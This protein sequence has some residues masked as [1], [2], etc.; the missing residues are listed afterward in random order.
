M[1][2]YRIVLL[3]LTLLMMTVLYT[4]VNMIHIDLPKGIA[5]APLP[6]SINEN[7][8]LST[9][10]TDD[11]GGIQTE[12]MAFCLQYWEQTANALKN[13]M[14]LQCWAKLNNI[15]K[16]LEPSIHFNSAPI[17]HF[18]NGNNKS[19]KFGD[20]FD[21]ENWNNFAS[22]LE[23]APLV[24]LQHFL[25][26]ATKELVYVQ[27]GHCH[28][29][30]SLTQKVWYSYLTT[31]GFRINRTACIYFKS[32]FMSES[33]FH[34]DILG[35]GG[36][37]FS[38]LFELWKG[39][40]GSGEPKRI[41]LKDSACSNCLS[42]YATLRM[43]PYKPKA[44]EYMPESSVYPILPSKRI[45]K[46]LDAFIERH[47]AGQE[48][49]AV[50]LRTEKIEKPV[51]LSRASVCEKRILADVNGM[52]EQRNISK[53]LLFSDT[54][55]HGS[56]T[57]LSPAYAKKF[58]KAVQ[59]TLHAELGESKMGLLFED[60]VQI[61]VLV[62][63]LVARARCVVMVGGGTFQAQSAAMYTHR[64]KGRECYS[65]RNS[66]CDSVYISRVFGRRLPDMNVHLRTQHRYKLI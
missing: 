54:G 27:F 33:A 13:L 8:N 44:I 36:V 45:L 29:I 9:K 59:D 34:E 51:L 5:P 35:S 64:H 50:T 30:K 48:Y 6:R 4:I 21:M 23:F 65:Q 25:E 7:L 55:E 22:E 37:K 66:S 43:T 63:E 11:Y 42:H 14:D 17:F 38:V 3:V 1:K 28:S 12:P 32:Q 52:K 24:S 56:K 57:W 60:S 26:H 16:V 53:V 2:V 39:I 31:K 49:I 19:L 15:S 58:V 61:A 18:N 62:S 40:R 46:H 41:P 47:L 20:V 10:V